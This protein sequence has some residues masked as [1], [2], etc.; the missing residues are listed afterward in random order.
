MTQGVPVTLVATVAPAGVQGSVGF[1]LNGAPISASIPIV[2]GG[3]DL[4]VD[5]ERRRPGDPR[6][7]LHDES[8]RLGLDH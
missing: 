1:T 4:P 6:C 8:G 5:A 3:L 7:Q 2:N